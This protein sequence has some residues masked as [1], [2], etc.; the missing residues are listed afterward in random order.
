MTEDER[1]ILSSI[2]TKEMKDIEELLVDGLIDY[3]GEREESLQETEKMKNTRELQQKKETNGQPTQQ[4]CLCLSLS[5]SVLFLFLLLLSSPS[6]VLSLE[7][8]K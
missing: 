1:E 6:Q 5:P 3:C 8:G 4:T 2:F 7:E